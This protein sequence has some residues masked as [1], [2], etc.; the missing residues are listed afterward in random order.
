[1]IFIYVLM[2]Y[3]T[4][5]PSI[6][7]SLLL[8][9]ILRTILIDLILQFSYINTKCIHHIHCHSPFPYTHSPPTGTHPWKRKSN[10]PSFFKVYIDSLRE[11][12]LG[13][14]GLYIRGF[15]QITHLLF[16]LSLSPC[17]TN[18][19]ELTVQYVTLYLYINGLFQYFSLSN[20]FFTSLEACFMN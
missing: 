6:V 7:F 14:S 5:T 15:N 9:P 2:I 10:C 3:L 20:I 4:F 11:S 17:S 12:C 16:T 1:L 18:I 8:S 19:Q 13:T